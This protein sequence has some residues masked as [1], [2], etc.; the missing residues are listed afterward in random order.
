MNDNSIIGFG[1]YAKRPLKRV[2]SDY[3]L[4]LWNNGKNKEDSPLANYIRRNMQA[5]QKEDSD[6]IVEPDEHPDEDERV[7][8]S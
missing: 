2:P 8:V 3:L 4:W 5:L 1:K 7:Q 6:T